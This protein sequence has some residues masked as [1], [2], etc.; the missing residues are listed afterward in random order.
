MQYCACVLECSNVSVITTISSVLFLSHLCSVPPLSSFLFPAFIPPSSVHTTTALPQDLVPVQ[1][2]STPPVLLHCSSSSSFHSCISAAWRSLRADYY[3]LHMQTSTLSLRHL[4]AADTHAHKSTQ[5]CN[6]PQ[7]HMC[8]G[9]SQTFL[10]HL[11]CSALHSFPSCLHCS[12][13]SLAP[14]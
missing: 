8:I 12:F 1:S 9:D 3:L 11:L 4:H 14:L 2:S 5:A 6:P 13:L 7:S 10:L